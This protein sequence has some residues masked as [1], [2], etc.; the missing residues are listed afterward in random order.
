MFGVVTRETEELDWAEF[1]RAFYELKDVTGRHT[2]PEPNA[3]NMISAFGD[4]DV[5]RTD[6]ALLAV[7]AEGNRATGDRASLDWAYVCPS[8]TEYKERLYDLVETAAAT[9]PDVRLDDVGFP[10]EEYCHC[11]RCESGFAE[12]D[13]E[14]WW[15]WRAAQVTDF[16]STAAD[17]VPGTTYVTLYP[18]PYPGHLYRRSG[19][20]LDALSAHV[21][22][23]VVPLYD[24][25]Y[26]TTYWLESIASGFEDRL[27]VDFSIELLAAL[28][29]MDNLVDAARVADAHAKDVYFG[30]DGNNASAAIRRLDAEEREGKT[31][32]APGE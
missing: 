21:D 6:P 7:D 16:V 32:G 2:D 25:E 11:E 29:P 5:A 3:V 8:V 28:V 31:F 18:D 23:Y 12:S 10:G 14:D 4:N 1:D 24:E 13:H 15:G 17:H 20:D 30:Y 27:D 9:S 26:A 22:E 19:I